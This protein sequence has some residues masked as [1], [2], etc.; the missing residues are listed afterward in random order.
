MFLIK[1]MCDFSSA[2]SLRNYPGDC[3]RFH[4][5]NWKVKVEVKSEKLDDSGMVLDFRVLKKYTKAIISRLDHR[6]INDVEPFTKI[7]PTAEN[8]CKYIFDNLNDK[9]NS[10]GFKLYKVTLWENDN[11]STTYKL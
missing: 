4:G 7:N 10:L 3:A 5:H 1:V 6:Y 2:H 8:I 11:A 9:F